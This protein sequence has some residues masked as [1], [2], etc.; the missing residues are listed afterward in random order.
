ME[1]SSVCVINENCAYTANVPEDWKF[2]ESATDYPVFAA[3]KETTKPSKLRYIIKSFLSPE[4]TNAEEYNRKSREKFKFA[5]III[6]CVIWTLVTIIIT[7][8]M[9][10]MVEIV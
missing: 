10:K 2:P 4:E 7:V 6:C 8:C 1:N 3:T 9:L 5:A